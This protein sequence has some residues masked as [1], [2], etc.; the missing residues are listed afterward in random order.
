MPIA[1]HQKG[2]RGIGGASSDRKLLFR[3]DSRVA[4]PGRVNPIEASSTRHV[5]IH[6]LQT[7]VQAS[8]SYLDTLL[9]FGKAFLLKGKSDSRGI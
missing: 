2:V 9:S 6:G 7:T 1:S 4:T 3:E 8:A 5:S